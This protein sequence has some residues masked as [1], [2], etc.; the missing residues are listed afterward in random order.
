MTVSPLLTSAPGGEGAGGDSAVNGGGGV[1]VAQGLLGLHQAL[2][3]VVDL[4]LLGPDVGVDG[5]GAHDQQGVPGVDVG[6]AQQVLGDQGAAGLSGDLPHLIVLGGAV[7]VGV[8]GSAVGGG[9]GGGGGH[10]GGEGVGVVKDHHHFKIDRA[11]GG[12]VADLVDLLHRA[13]EGGHHGGDGDGGALAHRDVVFVGVA[14]VQGELEPLVVGQG[15]DGLA[16]ADLLV[17]LELGDLHQLPG[18][19]GPDRQVVGLFHQVGHVLL[20]VIHLLLGGGH[21]ILGLLAADGVERLAHGDSVAGGHQDLLHGA[22]L[23]QGNGGRLLGRALP[24]PETT[25]W[26]E[27][28]LATWVWISLST[29]F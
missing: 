24:E 5:V 6:V 16:L 1:E 9:E 26:M 13:G 19:G 14:E 12:D 7:G 22:A 25:L 23:G 20:Q 2:G 28:M 3:G 15:A 17:G 10:V 4:L 21:G 18:E 11:L 29:V 8:D 27:E